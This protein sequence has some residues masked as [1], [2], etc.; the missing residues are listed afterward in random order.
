MVQEIQLLAQV[1]LVAVVILVLV[2][3][4]RVW[5]VQPILAVAEAVA[6]TNQV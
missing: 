3:L 5:Q 6:L 2:L 4:R 1:V